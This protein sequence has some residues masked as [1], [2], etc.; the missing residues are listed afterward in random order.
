LATQ[1]FLELQLNVLPSQ[2][3]CGYGNITIDGQ[4]LPQQEHND[5]WTG[6]GEITT[7][8]KNVIDA[9]WSFNCVKVNGV[10]EMQ[11]LKFNIARV[12]GIV[13]E[14]LGFSALFV[15]TGSTKIMNIITD[16]AVPDEVA[17]WE[18]SCQHLGKVMNSRHT[19][20]SKI[21]PSLIG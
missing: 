9:S 16:I 1:S 14:D 18:V 20:S 5:V 12:D 7:D 8:R 15:Q 3:V 17:A 21:L 13:V 10:P 6:K 19:A 2:E 11:Y 4:A